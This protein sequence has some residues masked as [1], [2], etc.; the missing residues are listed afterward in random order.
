VEHRTLPDAEL[1]VFAKISDALVHLALRLWFPALIVVPRVVE[2]AVQAAVQ[3][4]AATHARVASADALHVAAV[5][6][7]TMAQS[8]HPSSSVCGAAPF[9]A[10]QVPN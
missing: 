8:L 4:V 2:G 1:K 9:L 5:V 3:I 7:A 6:P 10:A